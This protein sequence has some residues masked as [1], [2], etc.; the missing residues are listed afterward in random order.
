MPESLCLADLCCVEAVEAEVLF[1]SGLDGRS[2]DTSCARFSNSPVAAELLLCV[3]DFCSFRVAAI[4]EP[5]ELLPKTASR[6]A[7]IASPGFFAVLEGFCCDAAALDFIVASMRSL[8]ATAA[9]LALLLTRAA[10]CLSA[11]ALLA[12]F[13]A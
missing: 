3:G 7:R 5:L 1:A 10:T 11:A 12:D 2:A 4:A 13:E 6:T 9:L 8:A